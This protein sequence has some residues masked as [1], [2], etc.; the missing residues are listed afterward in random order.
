MGHQ[1]LSPH[2]L[3]RGQCARYAPQL[4]ERGGLRF[5]ADSAL[6][7][8]RNLQSGGFCVHTAEG[9]SN[10]PTAERGFLFFHTGR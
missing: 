1:A 5:A 3:G 7:T 10:A 4:A 6:A 2:A 9:F 8:L